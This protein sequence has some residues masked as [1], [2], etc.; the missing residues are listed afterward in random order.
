[1]TSLVHTPLKDSALEGPATGSAIGW[2]PIGRA[3]ALIVIDMEKLF[4]HS[5]C[6]SSAL[7]TNL[8]YQKRYSGL[9]CLC[10]CSCLLSFDDN[11]DGFS[12]TVK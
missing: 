5:T 12:G 6:L 3:F 4:V 2:D 8:C 1:M 9:P 10:W 11:L 7:G